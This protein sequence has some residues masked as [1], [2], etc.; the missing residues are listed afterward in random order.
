[1]C[2]R[3]F[4]TKMDFYRN[5]SIFAQG[6]IPF[7]ISLWIFISRNIERRKSIKQWHLLNLPSLTTTF[8]W[9]NLLCLETRS[10]HSPWIHYVRF[11]FQCFLWFYSAKNVFEDCVARLEVFIICIIKWFWMVKSIRSV[12]T[13]FRGLYVFIP[14]FFSISIEIFAFHR[15]IRVALDSVVPFNLVV[16]GWKCARDIVRICKSVNNMYAENDA[17]DIRAAV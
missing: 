12:M 10:I 15:N 14:I 7:D 11:Y 9:S 3:I 4:E 6:F 16:V 5:G 8:V 13:Y 1:M 2:K 17:T